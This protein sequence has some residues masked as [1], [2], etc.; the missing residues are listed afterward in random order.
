MTNITDYL[1]NFTPAGTEVYNGPFTI[2]DNGQG[3]GVT[4]T[5]PFSFVGITGPDSRIGYLRDSD[6]T[7][8]IRNS[9]ESSEDYNKYVQYTGELTFPSP[10]MVTLEDAPETPL[11][12]LPNVR[13]RRIMPKN[14]PYFQTPSDSIFE[15][16]LLNYSFLQ[17]LYAFHETLDGF[18]PSEWTLRQTFNAGGFKVT[19]VADGTDP[20]D[21]ATFGQVE[22]YN[23]EV[24]ELYNLTAASEELARQYAA[25][26]VASKN[27]ATTKAT[28]SAS[29]ASASASSASSSLSS[30]NAAAVSATNAETSYQNVLSYD[31]LSEG[32]AEDA[33]DSASSALVSANIA[34]SNANFKGNWAGKTGAAV[35]PSS[36]YHEG[37]YWQLLNNLTNIAS[38]EPS[39][40]NP[41]YAFISKASI[42]SYE[43][44]STEYLISTFDS[45]SLITGDMV[46]TLGYYTEGDGGGADWVKSSDIGSPSLTPS[47]MNSGRLTSKAG[48]IFNLAS[49]GEVDV[50]QFGA[51]N[52]SASSAN[53]TGA[54]SAMGSHCLYSG[55]KW[56]ASGDFY[57]DTA[58][59]Y[60]SSHSNCT[61]FASNNGEA[62][63]VLVIKPDPVNISSINVADFNAGLPLKKGATVIPALAAY[64][65]HYIEIVASDLYLKRYGSTTSYR[66]EYHVKV[67]DSTGR[68]EPAL[69]FDWPATVSAVLINAEKIDTELSIEGVSIKLTDGVSGSRE[70]IVHSTR[71][72]TKI[73]IVADNDTNLPVLQI[74]QIEGCEN[75]LVNCKANRALVDNTNYGYNL[76]GCLHTLINCSE[77]DCRRGLDG[78]HVMGVTVIGGNYPSGIGAHLGFNYKVSD[79]SDIGS[80]TGNINSLHFT[81]GD[82][83]VK[84][85]TVTVSNGNIFAARS[86][87]PEVIGNIDLIGN[88]LIFDW[89]SK[90]GVPSFSMVLITTGVTSPDYGRTL[91]LPDNINVKDNN[92]IVTGTGHT[93]EVYKLL[94]FTVGTS[95][96]NYMCSSKV[97]FSGNSY[98]S[99]SVPFRVTVNKHSFLTGDAI[100]IRDLDYHDLGT[101][102]MANVPATYT[103]P[104]IDFYHPNGKATSFRSDYGWLR[105]GEIFETEYASALGNTVYTSASSWLA[106]ATSGD[107]YLLKRIEDNASIAVLTN[108]LYTS[109][110]VNVSN[111]FIYG[112]FMVDGDENSATLSSMYQSGMSIIDRVALTGTS[113]VDG[114]VSVSYTASSFYIEN[115]SGS[116][117]IVKFKV[118]M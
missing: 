22:N 96:N 94:M 118:N 62:N 116:A 24:L 92:V 81:G 6:V 12:N 33:E 37:Y 8:W 75:T 69:P 45:S 115:R 19:N 36:Y 104:F 84:N 77:T 5:F 113:G 21:V 48:S 90:T 44:E 74:M 28:E 79:V 41:N 16:D 117:K 47:V 105:N 108:K 56:V 71:A 111:T 9:D 25:S 55:D 20:Q 73:N 68:I 11:D 2:F 1:N 87:A 83:S 54:F 103:Q 46:K 53:S 58:D 114:N 107:K 10:N 100:V 95:T 59:V 61:L 97:T 82:I 91:A 39:A 31:I 18:I 66:Y 29:S 60:S 110:D 23:A 51:I 52:G 109:V 76:T 85:S 38:S 112:R 93:G 30:K 70:K 86:D 88:N 4:L 43:V 15:S 32:Y 26:A 65:G 72:N 40:S 78:Q 99:N 63:G 7:V 67:I 106:V 27:T 3:D 50:K 80:S 98:K 34:Q 35:V 17:Q 57:V 13:V 101:V 102:Y 89:M 14:T 42:T 64:E 49:E